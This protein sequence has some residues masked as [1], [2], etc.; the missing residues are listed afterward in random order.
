MIYLPT[1]SELK[2]NDPNPK[3]SLS[4]N[5]ALLG[6]RS[7]YSSRITIEIETVGL[8]NLFCNAIYSDEEPPYK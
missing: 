1:Y 6:V 4:R 5:C 2:R 7:Y 3:L 8:R